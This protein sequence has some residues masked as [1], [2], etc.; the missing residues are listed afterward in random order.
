MFAA[1][2]PISVRSENWNFS[3]HIVRR[4][5]PAFTKHMCRH[6]GRGC[7]AMHSRDHNAALGLHDCGDGFR[8]PEQRSSQTARRKENW[9]VVLD[10][11]RKNNEVGSDRMLAEMLVM[12][13]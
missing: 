3:A 11:R 5:Q 8:A 1:R 7:L 13:T 4:M 12:K 9:I 10:C 6:R 2:V